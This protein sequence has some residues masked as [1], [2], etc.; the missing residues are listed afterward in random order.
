VVGEIQVSILARALSLCLSP[1]VCVLAC[2]LY[3]AVACVVGL[4]DGELKKGER[5]RKLFHLHTQPAY[6]CTLHAVCPPA[7]ARQDA[8]RVD[9][10]D[11]QALQIEARQ[12]PYLGHIACVRAED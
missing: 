12:Q 2:S 5:E 8:A 3:H 1:C 11:A 7:G 10:E 9:D 6:G 4:S